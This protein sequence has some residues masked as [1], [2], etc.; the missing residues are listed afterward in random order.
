MK[1]LLPTVIIGLIVLYFMDAAFHI[2]NWN[3]EMF[4]HNTVRF[5]S[6]FVVLG[7]WVWYK[8]RLKLKAAL[9]FVLALLVSDEIMDYFRDIDNLRLELVIHDTFVV[10]WGSVIGFFYMRGLKRKSSR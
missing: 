7:I 2:E 4:V 8:H 10:I 1:T 5:V 3:M 6:G 9:Y